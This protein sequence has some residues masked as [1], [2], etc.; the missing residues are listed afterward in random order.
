VTAQLSVEE[1][2]YMARARE[3]VIRLSLVAIMGVSCFLL[4][5]PFLFLIISGIIIAIAIYPGYRMLKKVLG[6]REALVRWGLI[7]TLL[8]RCARSELTFPANAR[9]R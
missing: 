7:R 3:V 5:R 6:G 2:N 4:L 9:S 1:E 8:K